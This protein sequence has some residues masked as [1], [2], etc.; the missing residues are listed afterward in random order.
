MGSSILVPRYGVRAQLSKMRKNDNQFGPALGTDAAPNH[1]AT[2]V[3]DRGLN[4]ELRVSFTPATPNPDT[5]VDLA[6]IKKRESFHL[7]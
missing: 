1:A 4:V 3:S 5:F 2:V 7:R 6:K